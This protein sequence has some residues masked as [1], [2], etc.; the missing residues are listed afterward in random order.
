V[1]LR[2][3]IAHALLFAITL[4]LAFPFRAGELRFDLGAAAGWLA[5]A[6]LAAL[7]RDLGP[8]AAFKWAFFSSWLGFTLIVF[9]LYVVV[10]VHGGAPAIAGVAAVLVVSGVFAAHAGA[11]GALWV[12]LAPRAGRAAALVLPAAWLVM[13]HLRGFD[14]LGGFTWASLGYA[15]HLDLPMLG[16]ASLGGVHALSFVTALAG[17]L[18]GLG[19]WP[20]ALAVVA[21]AHGIGFLALPSAS[22]LAA[23]R[24]PPLRVAMVQGNI[25]QGEKWDPARAQRNFDVH[26]ELSR[27]VAAER[28]DLILWPESALPGFLEAQPEFRDPLLALASEI[29]VPLVVGGIGLSRVPGERMPL[30]H[31]SLFVVTPSQGVVDRY[32][33]TVLVPFGEYVPLRSLLGFL[34]AVA[35]TLADLSDI[36]PG[37]GARPL[38][39]LSEFEPAQTPVGLIC[40]EAVY[41]ELVRA[42]VRGGAQ[43]LMNLTNDAWYSRTSAPHQFLAIAALRSAENGLPMLRAANTGVSAVIDARGVVLRETPIFE[44]LTLTAEIPPGRKKPTVYTRVGDW[45]IAASWLL[46]VGCAGFTLLRRSTLAP[47]GRPMRPVDR[48]EPLD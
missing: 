4:A 25:P 36:S 46:L 30:L 2:T 26:L 15:T 10:T 3:R 31:N 12:W 35:S 29:D 32:D 23:P 14:F 7:L 43:L 47:P 8:R 21:V 39:G 40:Y 44:R 18:L 17:T 13:E 27:A 1:T 45:P 38:R 16:L 41:P 20:A 24:D 22:D 48:V 9:W 5:L 19:R 42:A 28:P 33:K 37:A 6:P 34:S 11:A